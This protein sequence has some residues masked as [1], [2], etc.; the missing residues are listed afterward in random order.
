MKAAVAA[1]HLK[2]GFVH[3]NVGECMRQQRGWTLERCGVVAG[4]MLIVGAL[5]GLLG[6]GPCLSRT[7]VRVGVE[8]SAA[9][10]SHES[11]AGGG[12]AAAVEQTAVEHL[13]ASVGEYAAGAGGG[14]ADA[15][16]TG[17]PTAEDAVGNAPY[18]DEMVNSCQYAARAVA[19]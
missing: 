18:A 9:E 8:E 14:A 1:H 19:R 11:A 13:G 15:A 2:A 4:S 6:G 5:L 3:Q 10:G 16:A 7:L 17:M 12:A